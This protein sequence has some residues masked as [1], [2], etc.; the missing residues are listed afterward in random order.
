MSQK[1][2]RVR[3]APSP[4]G[5][6]H[7]GGIRTA[8]YNYLFAKKNNGDFI[9]RIE[10]T[11]QGRYVPGAEKYIIDA[12]NWCGLVP[13]ESPVSPG[14]FG[15]YRQ[16]E[17]KQMYRQYADM[18]IEKG[19]AYYAFDSP[20]DLENMRD[21]AK[22]AKMP[23][24]QYN[25]ISRTSMKNSLTLSADET[26]KM[27]ANGDPF[28][29][30]IKMPRNED[31]RFYD[32]IRGWVIVN[33]NNMDDKV[34]F[35]GDGMPTY[36]LA[37]VVDDYNMKISHV[38]RGEEWLPS[39]PL[40][41]LLYKYLGWEEVM[42]KFAHLPLILKPD[43]N[44]KLSK[45]DGD[46]LGFPVF[47]LE[48]T[49]PETKEVSS[50]YKEKGYFKDAFINMLAFLGWNPG[51][52]REIFSLPELIDAFSLERVGKSGAKFDP[53]KTKWFNQQYLRSKSNTELAEL[54][55]HKTSHDVCLEYL[56]GVAGLMKE[57]ASF[58]EE[59]LLDDY[60]FTAPKEY[61]AKTLRKKW[62][63][64]TATN[65]ELLKTALM[66]ISDFKA[67]KIE[68]V[69]KDFLLKNELGMGAALPNFRLLVTG[70]GM[71][72]S[73][74]ETAA[75]LGKDEVLKRFENGIQSIENI[76]A[77]LAT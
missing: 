64:A 16:S 61:D 42:P 69:F 18:L 71:G 20:E 30:R 65:M 25:V 38:I 60:F 31:V 72:P 5:P 73:M 53:D 67:E 70:K 35:K 12:L 57:R 2:V 10:D 3:F 15:P 56:E 29:I 40:H 50:G 51:D 49:D 74:F 26:E 55:Q 33:T 7:M 14:D 62:K 34:I 19:Y 23:N 13:D 75:L 39:A 28:T 48:W 8:L 68:S 6:L 24:W 27:L 59:L 22:K 11:D 41:V 32:E 21:L 37:N 52:S 54:L 36:H 63:P 44:G 77:N 1:N 4:T 17:R 43:G 76:K 58:V 66:T 45:R 9:L 46:R 47:P